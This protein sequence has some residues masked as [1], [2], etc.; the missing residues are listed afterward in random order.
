MPRPLRAAASSECLLVRCAHW[1][2]VG[3]RGL[4]RSAQA[5]GVRPRSSNNRGSSPLKPPDV[6]SALT[7]KLLGSKNFDPEANARTL[8]TDFAL[9]ASRSFHR[10]ILLMSRATR[11]S[12]AESNDTA[13]EDQNYCSMQPM[14]DCLT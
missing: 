5:Q 10:L 2:W 12:L 14:Q 3:S 9:R 7:R 8:P 13:E 11:M 6:A 1:P 4:S